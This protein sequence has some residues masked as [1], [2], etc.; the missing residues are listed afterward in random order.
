MLFKSTYI[1]YR[2]L[3]L[4]KHDISVDDSSI[5]EKIPFSFETM[6]DVFDSYEKC[7]ESKFYVVDIVV[8]TPFIV[9]KTLFSSEIIID[10]F[11]SL[12]ELLN[13]LDMFIDISVDD[14]N[15]AKKKYLLKKVVKSIKYVFD[16]AVDVSVILVKFLISIETIIDNFISVE[17][18]VQS[19]RYVVNFCVDD[20]SGIV[21]KISFSFETIVDIFVSYG[22]PVIIFFS[23]FL[24]DESS[25]FSISD[26][27]VISGEES[28]V[29]SSSD[30]SGLYDDDSPESS[31]LYSSE[32][33]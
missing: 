7:V 12:K 14:S 11:S 25:L 17:R 30:S 15:M 21:V 16:T 26:S 8:R 27:S 20:Y 19:I 9:V 4:Y 3:A 2:I 33:R 24:E 13:P 18:I 23:S 31:I 1:L 10:N 6:A 29:L 22:K 28:L 32:F 5:G